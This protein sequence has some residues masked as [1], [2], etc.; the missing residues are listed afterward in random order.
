MRKLVDAYNRWTYASRMRLKLIISAEELPS[1]KPRMLHRFGYNK[2]YSLAKGMSP[3]ITITGVTN[4]NSMEPVIDAGHIALIEDKP[5]IQDLV[6]GDIVLFY[7]R[8]DKNPR[9]L[10][11]IVLIGND[12]KGWYCETRGDNTVWLDG[13]IR[14]QDILGICVAIIY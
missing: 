1:P 11:R 10:H 8:L 12:S 3:T 2:I 7:R 4:T 6:V 5:N 14:Y 9:V 13:K